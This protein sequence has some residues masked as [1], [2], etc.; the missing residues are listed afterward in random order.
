MVAFKKIKKDDNVKILSGRDVGKTGK[1]VEVDRNNG[2][3]L[4]EGINII[5]KTMKKTQKNQTGGIKEV[6][7]FLDISNVMLVCPKCK[8]TTRVGFKIDK[9]TKKRICKKCSTEIE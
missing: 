7:S 8:K 4:V 2:K 9:D 3:V 6:E 1:V 5:K